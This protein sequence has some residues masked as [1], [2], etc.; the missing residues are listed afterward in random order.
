[1]LVFLG[2][3]V[4]I[5]ILVVVVL[6]DR[7]IGVVVVFTR[8]RYVVDGNIVVVVVSLLFNFR[9]VFFLFVDVTQLVGYTVK[10]KEE[11][12]KKNQ[13]SR[14]TKIIFIHREYEFCVVVGGGG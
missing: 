1:M 12:Q 6:S 13:K 14:K 9:F 5:S 11:K 10:L 7:G 2:Y 3:F 8:P 4:G